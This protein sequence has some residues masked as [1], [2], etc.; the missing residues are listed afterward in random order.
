L[1]ILAYIYLVR[2]LL[3]F[4]HLAGGAK[5]MTGLYIFALFV[6]PYFLVAKGTI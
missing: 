2:W 4:H 1:A 3:F 5:K 6:T